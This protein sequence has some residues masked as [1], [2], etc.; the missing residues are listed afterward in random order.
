MTMLIRGISNRQ[1]ALFSGSTFGKGKG[2]LKLQN[3]QNGK[4]EP[5]NIF[6]FY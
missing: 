2:G 3:F 1:T 5:R 4:N 6:S